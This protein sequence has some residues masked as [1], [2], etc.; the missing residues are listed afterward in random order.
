MSEGIEIRER[1]ATNGSGARPETPLEL[2]ARMAEAIAPLAEGYDRENRFGEESLRLLQ[3]SGYAALTVPRRY[4]GGGAGLFDLVRAQERLAMG[5]G[6]VALSIGMSLIAL[7]EQAIRPT[8]PTALYERVMRAAA[9]RGALVNS[10]ATEP[11]LG[12]PS[13][14]G[15]PETVAVPA[16]RGG[17]FLSGHKTWAS[18]A[19][20]LD[21]IVTTATIEDGSQ[22]VGRFMVERGEGVR[23]VESW[24]SMGMRATGSHDLLF[25]AAYV[26]A[27]H[28]LKRSGGG[29]ETG[30]PQD[31]TGV[32]YQNPF[33]SLPVAA[34][35]LG[36][37]A[38]AQQTAVAYAQERVPPA[39]G[40]PLA[41]VETV[42]ERLAEN[43][44]AMGLSRIVLYD[45][46]RRV[47]ACGGEMDDNLQLDV[48]LAKESV[49]EH[50]ISIVDRAGRVV[51]GAALSSGNPL[52]RAYRNVRAGLLHPPAA[53]VTR[54]L[55]AAR[56][57]GE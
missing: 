1:D 8:W 16:P 6:A 12:S 4:G 26:P 51:G 46:A 28:L 17:W 23:V 22:A 49:T 11:N 48:Y 27:G 45:V 54:R 25:E 15:R 20:M 42:R 40:R 7:V 55:F 33:F 56:A 44:M 30:V 5:D 14:G 13:R 18:L 50:A 2:A 35:Y 43:E 53:D 21:F 3:A 38:A 10:V 37:A 34:V 41:T 32:R 36:I 9:E 39:L 57:L 24:D 31:R 29:D 19:P 52:E 47:E